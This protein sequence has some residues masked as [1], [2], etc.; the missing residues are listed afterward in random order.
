MSVTVRE[1]ANDHRNNDA[2]VAHF[3]A[4]SWAIR[5]EGFGGE[6]ERR[7]QSGRGAMAMLQVG[8]R[9]GHA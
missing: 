4:L 5:K 2:S 8:A 9:I 6:E 1:V 3:S 7:A